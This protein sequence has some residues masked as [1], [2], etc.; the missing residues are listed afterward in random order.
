MQLLYSN[1]G[2]CQLKNSFCIQIVEYANSSSFC[3]Q[4][5]EDYYRQMTE[6][7]PDGKISPEDF[8]KIFRL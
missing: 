4:I 6:K 8:K 5:V 1:C 7:Y 3:V 2:G